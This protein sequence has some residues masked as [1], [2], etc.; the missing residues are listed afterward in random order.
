MH[1]FESGHWYNDSNSKK[2][3]QKKKE[4]KKEEKTQLKQKKQIKK[5]KKKDLPDRM[6]LT[7]GTMYKSILFSTVIAVV[8]VDGVQKVKER[9]IK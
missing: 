5:K 1:E 2:E 8:L 4:K 6:R 3:S 9:L 7:L